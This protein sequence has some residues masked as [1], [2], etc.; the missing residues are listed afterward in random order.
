M[1]NIVLVGGVRLHLLG[2]F[3]LGRHGYYPFPWEH[4]DER[5]PFQVLVFGVLAVLNGCVVAHRGRAVLKQGGLTV[6]GRER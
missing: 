4:V 5:V 6:A 3:F 2:A 1:G